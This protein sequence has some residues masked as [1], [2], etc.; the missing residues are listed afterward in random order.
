MLSSYSF[1]FYVEDGHACCPA[2]ARKAHLDYAGV[3]NKRVIVRNKVIYYGAGQSGAGG[4]PT[5]Y[6]GNLGYGSELN[7]P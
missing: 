6:H 2:S 1:G 5:G 3:R 7:P 4:A